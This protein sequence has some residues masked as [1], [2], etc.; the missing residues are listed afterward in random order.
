MAFRN[1]A[2]QILRFNPDILVIPE[3]ESEEK[4]NFNKHIKTPK[5]K[6]WVGKNINKGLLVASYSDFYKI[7]INKLYNEDCKYILP[8]DVSYSNADFIL[9]AVWTQS[10]GNSYDSYVV[11]A[12]RAINYYIKLLGKDS[13]IIGDFN[14]NAIWDDGDKKEATHTDL[15]NILS[16]IG[17]ESLYH[18][19]TNTK[20]GQ[21]QDSTLY[22]HR[23]EHKRYHVDYI[24]SGKSWTNKLSNIEIGGFEDW[25]K[26]SDH[27]PIIADFITETPVIENIHNAY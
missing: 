16:K 13:I 11:Q 15:V 12:Y 18:T 4:I 14:S 6:L 23:K 21:E 20:Q 19:K 3:S 1:K 8:I 5:Q 24:F 27:M 25:I 26:Y 2:D 22:L 9:L 7:G 17:I 10:T